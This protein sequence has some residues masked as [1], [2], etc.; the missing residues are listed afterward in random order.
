[1]DTRRLCCISSS[2]TQLVSRYIQL[3][4][5]RIVFIKT[6]RE[7]VACSLHKL[8]PRLTGQHTRTCPGGLLLQ[9]SIRG[10]GVALT[11]RRAL[12]LS[13]ASYYAVYDPRFPDALHRKDLRHPPFCVPPGATSCRLCGSRLC[14][15]D[16][17][18]E[19][20]AYAPCTFRRC[21]STTSTRGRA[22]APTRR[23]RPRPRPPCNLAHRVLVGRRQ[24]AKVCFLRN[25]KSN[26]KD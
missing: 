24:K 15:E 17:A 20:A 26:T 2:R 19:V 8:T 21:P 3:G 14:D 5:R 7:D 12:I 23:L 22:P 25:N 11:T 1:M 18:L 13:A 4:P 9:S 16:S 6:L 10:R